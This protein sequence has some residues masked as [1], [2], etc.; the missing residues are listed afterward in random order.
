MRASSRQSRAVSHVSRDRARI[1]LAVRVTDG[2]ERLTTGH[3]ARTGE[4]IEG[5]DGK[6]RFGQGQPRLRAQASEPA[7]RCLVEPPPLLIKR[8]QQ[9][10]ECVGERDFREL[11]RE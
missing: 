10:R 5:G 9:Q 6:L 4:R 7:R 3:R 11:G 8:E 1:L 2:D